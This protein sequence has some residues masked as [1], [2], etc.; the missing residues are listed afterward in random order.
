MNN[1]E[2]VFA[3]VQLTDGVRSAEFAQN[4]NIRLLANGFSPERPNK[5]DEIIG[6][7]GE[8]KDVS[9]DLRFNVNSDGDM[10]EVIALI[11]D[12]STLLDNADL[13]GNHN[14]EQPVTMRVLLSGSKLSAPLEAVLTGSDGRRPMLELPN[15]FLQRLAVGGEVGPVVVRFSR[16]GQLL[17]A[18]DTA[19][20]S[21][22]TD[23][24][25]S[26]SVR[27]G[28]VLDIPS[29]TK[30]TIGLQKNSNSPT[31][32]SY[33]D[34]YIVVTDSTT[35]RFQPATDDDDDDS[36][37]YIQGATRTDDQS[38]HAFGG[39]VARFDANGLIT[40]GYDGILRSHPLGTTTAAETVVPLLS[41]R[42]NTTSVDWMIRAVSRLTTD[43]AE[44]G[45]PTPWKIVQ[46]TNTDV[47]V[48][49]LGPISRAS[50]RHPYLFIEVKA[51]NDPGVSGHTLDVNSLYPVPMT[52]YAKIIKINSQTHTGRE[53]KEF[54]IDHR[55]LSD[56][57]P[58]I[59][60]VDDNG[61]EALM[62]WNGYPFISTTGENISVWVNLPS[63]TKWA[64]EHP[65]EGGP[66]QFN[67]TVTRHKAYLIPV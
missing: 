16:R 12:V 24:P 50:G 53:V 27:L 44:V 2:L 9:S 28:E 57:A 46:R 32:L 38:N 8:Y 10:D 65:S 31:G 13:W 7:H 66:L 14:G 52:K 61:D 29:P 59:Y 34:G 47:Q 17:G 19:T 20:A 30:V 43:V 58:R 41:V 18:A 26:T 5:A 45:I 62:A 22:G 64:A 40:A 49:N 37:I 11:T 23:I 4:P 63:G 3:I 33:N 6:G 51:L 54:S 15:N 36:M 21:S 35:Q 39:D 25:N 1:D 60:S 67:L 55:V 42:N 48:L 56:R